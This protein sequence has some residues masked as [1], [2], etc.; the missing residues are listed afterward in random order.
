MK[1]VAVG[2]IG[3][4]ENPI[5]CG[6]VQN[7]DYSNMCYSL[8]NNEWVTSCSMNSSRKYPAAA[9]LQ[10]GRLLVTGG[11]S[12]PSLNTAEM[13]GEEGLER[14][15]PSLPVTIAYHCMVTLN[16]TTVMAI[17]G[18][19]DKLVSGKTFYFTF[20]A[21]S[22][23]EG[24]ELKIKRRCHSCGRIRRDKKGQEMSVI[25]A[26]GHDSGL[27]LESVEI[28]DAG[29]NEWQ[30][31]VEL[32]LALWWSQIVEDQNG[33][34]ILIGG[35]SSSINNLNTLYRLTHGGQD[36]EWT[37]ME[38]KLKIGRSRHRAF[39]VPDHIADCS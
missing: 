19:Q 31:G 12:G 17:G 18:F 13:L 32:P 8:E 7:K 35:S 23:I 36:A 5:I 33:G 27:P 16:L 15:L 1:F 28:L 38:Q 26:G 6:G 21:E 9:Q 2:G 14:K 25:V 4:Q 29:S 10:S 37:E 39:L 11:Y 30:T 3:P 34:V 24:P 20:G 22:W